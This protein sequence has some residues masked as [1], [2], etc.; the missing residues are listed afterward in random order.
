MDRYSGYTE[1]DINFMPSY[2]RNRFDAGY[3]NK[4]N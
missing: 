2:K 1:Y 3:F 4:K